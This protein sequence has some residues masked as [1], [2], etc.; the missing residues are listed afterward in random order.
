MAHFPF[1]VKEINEKAGAEVLQWPG[2]G[3]HPSACGIWHSSCKIN[4]E[5][6]V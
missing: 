3:V 5:I 4:E 6:L 2:D 1:G